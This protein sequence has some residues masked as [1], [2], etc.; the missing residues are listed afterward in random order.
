MVD[1]RRL[2]IFLVFIS[3]LSRHWWPCHHWRRAASRPWCWTWPPRPGRRAPWRCGRTACWPPPTPSPSR[4]CCR[5]R[6]ARCRGRSGL[7]SPRTCGL[8][9]Y[10]TSHYSLQQTFAKIKEKA[11]IGPSS[12]WKRRCKVHNR[13][14]ALRIYA[15]QTA[16]PS[17]PFVSVTQFH[18]YLPWVNTSLV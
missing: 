2:N 10:I 16:H 13:Q 11:P 18:F 3:E 7:R 8:W 15:N 5:S 9:H 1:K 17:W 4:R 14:A 12:D 6:S